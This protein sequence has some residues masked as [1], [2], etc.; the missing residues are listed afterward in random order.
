MDNKGI[1]KLKIIIIFFVLFIIIYGVYVVNKKDD[2]LNK[3]IMKE[4]N[5][6]KYREEGLPVVDVGNITVFSD[7]DEPNVPTNVNNNN[8]N[9][10]MVSNDTQ[11]TIDIDSNSIPIGEETEFVGY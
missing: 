9:N 7:D 8:N 2:N 10:Y 11:M 4:E 6:V 5:Q 1:T 3:N